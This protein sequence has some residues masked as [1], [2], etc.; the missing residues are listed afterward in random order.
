M[1]ITQQ[2][3][4]FSPIAIVLETK[5]DAAIF[6]DIVSLVDQASKPHYAMARKIS[7]WFSN[8]AKL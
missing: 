2:S 1:K 5:E 6:W 8:E 4:E 7:D 3:K